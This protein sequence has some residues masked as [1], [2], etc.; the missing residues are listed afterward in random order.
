MASFAAF[1]STL[2]YVAPIV[3]WLT[4]RSRR[5]RELW[6]VA[7]DI[8]TAVALDLVLILLLARL[9]P[10]ESAV[11][12]S[13]P[14][15]LVGLALYGWRWARRTMVIPRALGLR[16]LGLVAAAMIVALLLSTMISQRCHVYDRGWHIP[17][18]S[19]MRGQ[20]LPFV[21][22][23]Q[24]DLALAYHYTGDV[25]AAVFQTLSWSVL[26]A[27]RA[28]SLAH[29]VLF[30]L[31]AATIALLLRWLGLRRLTHAALAAG[32]VLLAGP[33]TVL[34]QTNHRTAAGYSFINFLKLS[35]RPHSALTGLLLV[36]LLTLLI[37]R[38]RRIDQPPPQRRTL[39]GLL[40][41]AAVLTITDEL[42]IG[43]FGLALG[44]TWLV[45]PGVLHPRRLGGAA[46]LGA[47]LAV[48]VLAQLV[49]GGSLVMGTAEHQLEWV[50]WRSPGYFQT[51]LPL[52]DPRGWAVFVRD[53]AALIALWGGTVLVVLRGR[54]AGR[55]G[56][57]VFC[58]VL[59]ATALIG[60][61]RIELV[62]PGSEVPA[63]GWAVQN[64]RFMTAPLVLLPLAG[65]ISLL[66]AA[67][68]RD[69]RAGP[70]AMGAA[71]IVGALVLG[72]ASTIRWWGMARKHECTTPQLYGGQDNFFKVDCREAVGARLGERPEPVYAAKSVLYLV[73][74]CRPVFTAGPPN[75]HYGL[76]IG[77]AQ[78]GMPA[79]IE[80]ARELSAPKGPMTVV[81]PAR[82][83]HAS[84]YPC[85]LAKREGRCEPAG[86]LTLRCELSEL[87]RA[88]ILERQGQ[89]R[90]IPGGLRRGPG[91]RDATR[92][93]RH[94]AKDRAGA[95]GLTGAAGSS[96]RSR[97]SR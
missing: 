37:A 92:I 46:I 39:P 96:A 66:P 72:G 43:L 48:L 33:L 17:L 14:I 30:G 54:T 24:P 40:A 4:V 32:G 22:V 49:F 36:G 29:D 81:C 85:T 47:L 27:S 50:P 73:A 80:V 59:F 55:L 58:T 28:L 31:T 67:A 84:G 20:R 76:K 94:R 78:F 45:L 19:S 38:L 90:L 15:W 11:L 52:S 7:L 68:T 26:H 18:V 3:G 56:L 34:A 10:L 86:E 97:R 64:H 61:G 23:Y 41:M 5:Q 87:Q 60:L 6:E 13:R 82:T 63:G 69:T 83:T 16:E 42:A 75:T 53:L 51:T 2:L 1:C 62:A 91:R 93:E 77:R 88:S 8:P 57:A 71:L 79:F 95:R 25:L 74:G 65:L 9:V 89:R 21:N 44:A 35:F 12:A 70:G